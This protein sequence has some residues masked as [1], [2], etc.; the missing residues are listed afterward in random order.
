MSDGDKIKLFLVD[1]DLSFLKTLE[2]EFMKH[3]DFEIQ[4]FVSGEC[5]IEQ[6]VDNP[7]AVILDY[8]LHGK[9]VTAKNGIQTLDAIKAFNKDIPVIMLSAQDKLEIAVNCMHHKAYDYVVKSE[10]VYVRLK[11]DVMT[12]FHFKEMK[13]Q[14]A[15]FV[16]RM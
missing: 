15:W 3:C 7:D 1:N 11:R 9:S 4:T 5:C 14:L 8:H 2:N 6:L 16:D 12:I 13:Q 10:T